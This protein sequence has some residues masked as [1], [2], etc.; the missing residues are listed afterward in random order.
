MGECAKRKRRRVVIQISYARSR[1]G[2]R[3]EGNCIPKSCFTPG[4]Q[5]PGLSLHAVKRYGKA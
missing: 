5:L 1:E 2:E 3:E 4:P